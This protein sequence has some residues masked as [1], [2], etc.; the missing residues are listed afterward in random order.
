MQEAKSTVSDKMD[1]VGAMDCDGALEG[2]EEGSREGA[3]LG[4]PEG[5]TVKVGV[6]E[7]AE[8]G[9]SDGWLEGAGV[10]AELGAGETVGAFVGLK[11]GMELGCEEGN[12]EGKSVLLSFMRFRCSCLFKSSTIGCC[13]PLNPKRASIAFSCFTMCLL[14]T[15]L[16]PMRNKRTTTD[17]HIDSL[18]ETIFIIICKRVINRECCIYN[19]Q[20]LSRDRN[21]KIIEEC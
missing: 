2:S 16:S 11:V 21:D 17:F 3:A 14:A 4:I 6:P 20:R 19:P 1:L 9:A 13:S 15:T 5:M 7:G 18:G 8:V 12:G 10:G